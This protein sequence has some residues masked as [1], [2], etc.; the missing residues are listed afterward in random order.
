M[1]KRMTWERK[2]STHPAYP[3]EGPAHPAYAG[4]DPEADA[5]ENGDPSSWGEDPMDG[6][7]V[8]SAHP[9][10]PDEGPAS[11]AYDKAAMERK[12]AKCIRIASAMLGKKASVSNVESQALVLMD[13]DNRAIQATLARLAAEDESDDSDDETPKA[14]E[15]KKANL[16]TRMARLRRLAAEAEAEEEAEEDPKAAAKAARLRRLA[17]EADD[18]DDDDIAKTAECE[19]CDDEEMLD[20][21]LM[22]ESMG[23]YASQHRAGDDD[24]EMLDDMLMEESMG[25]Y[26]RQHRGSDVPDGNQQKRAGK[27]PSSADKAKAKKLFDKWR[28]EADGGAEMD[29]LDESW[30]NF[31]NGD[32]TLQVLEDNPPNKTARLR[33]ARLR[34]LRAG[35]EEAEEEVK[36]D[37]KAAA[38]MARLR[39]LVRRLAA[40]AEAEEEAEE[41]PKAAAK[42][43]SWHDDDDA[44]LESMMAEEGM[45]ADDDDA[46]LESMMA[47]EGMMADDYSE[48]PMGSNEFSD[49][50]MITEDFSDDP[51]GVVDFD[52]SPDERLLM[53]KLFGKQAEKAPKAEDAAAPE[54]DEEPKA[55]TVKKAGFRPQ[56]RKAANGVTRLGGGV[57]KDAS[58]ANDLSRLWDSAPDV[59]KYF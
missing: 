32:L 6:P 26:A 52:M 33:L 36:E 53:A 39:R 9:A 37:P 25:K 23:K 57:T 10:Y 17:A 2:A 5:Y 7:Y 30:Q 4:E 24:E 15:A 34:S 54:S 46:L 12:A 21:M 43:A 49:D 56:P 8:Q 29:D 27:K 59:S 40:E 44:L 20:A 45:M 35:E 42:K 55:A 51:M 16:R 28:A 13:L 14:E 48:M 47:E 19:S 3:D 11:P 1:R 50:G 41:D 58:D 31:L 38:K 18:D 22:E